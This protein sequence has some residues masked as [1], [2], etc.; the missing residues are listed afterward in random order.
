MGSNCLVSEMRKMTTRISLSW[1]EDSVSLL[2]M[3]RCGV[4]RSVSS[5]WQM[6]H[7]SCSITSNSQGCCK[8]WVNI[9]KVLACTN[10]SVSSFFMWFWLRWLWIIMTERNINKASLYHFLISL[11][12]FC[13]F[14]FR[15]YWA[16]ILCVGFLYLRWVEA[17]LRCSAHRSHSLVAEV[18]PS[19]RGL[20]A[21][22][23]GPTGWGPRAR[24][25]SVGA[26]LGLSRSAACGILPDRGS[27]LCP[28]H[29]Q[30]DSCPLCH[31]GSPHF[32]F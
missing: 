6:G 11:K 19:V 13:P 4:L 22:T 8:H 16:F 12:I 28:L 5:A 2:F 3:E 27:N 25:L 9:C 29:W 17:A 21:C 31:Q 20:Q 23:R 32:I 26:A 1:Y 18:R 7:V 14:S 10:K 15:L 24:R 30:A